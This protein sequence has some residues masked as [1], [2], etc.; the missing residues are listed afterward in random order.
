M[1]NRR[2]RKRSERETTIDGRSGKDGPRGRARDDGEGAGVRSV[3]RTIATAGRADQPGVPRR[4]PLPA[5][6]GQGDGGIHRPGPR[7][8][9]G[10]GGGEGRGEP[11]GNAFRHG[12]GDGEPLRGGGRD[13]VAGGLPH[14]R[15]HRHGHGHRR[16]PWRPRALGSPAPARPPEPARRFANCT[17]LARNSR[18]GSSCFR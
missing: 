6:S 3:Q 10:A 14:P 9:G 1:W 12:R 15:G 8:G 17:S 5:H 7:E 2:G 13:D 11:G 16:A 4:R 18:S